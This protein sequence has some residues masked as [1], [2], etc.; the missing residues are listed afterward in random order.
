MSGGV[1]STIAAYILKK[2]G[3][4]VIG[5]CLNFCDNIDEKNDTL[6]WKVCEKL[7]NLSSQL[8]IKIYEKDYRKEFKDTVIKY[9]VDEYKKG[10]T[11][12]PCAYCNGVMKFEK[13]LSAMKEYGA[14]MIATGHYAKVGYIDNTLNGRRYFIKKSKNEQKDQSYMLY[15]LS[16]EQLSHLIL[17]IGDMDKSEVRDLAK[18][19]GF[20]E[21]YKKDSQDVCFILKEQL[22]EDSDYRE[23]IKRYDFGDDYK[24]QIARGML[25]DVDM[26]KVSYL[27][28]GEF[29]DTKGN[30][31][32]FH[33]GIINYT[34]GQRKGLN[35]AFGE[36]KFVVD[37]N[38]KENRI[39]LGDND[40]LFSSEFKVKTLNGQKIDIDCIVRKDLCEKIFAKVRYRHA[41]T[42]C[43]VCKDDD[44]TIVCKLKEPV[45]AIT[46]GQAAVF[47]DENDD[48]LFGGTII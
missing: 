5:I 7:N 30:V 45:R 43:I 40:E 15:S 37:I 34:I 36:R 19:S 47:Y 16:Q 42:E 25:S 4:E 38:V 13:L 35:I 6:D 8:G 3:H 23:F 10:Y 39:V 28:K 21:A 29:V 31:L 12:N 41:G 17:P 22:G 33:K 18:E 2:Q 20:E 14:D 11:P 24:E 46:R 1:D 27:Q 26:S 44:E 9:F 32:G 48:I